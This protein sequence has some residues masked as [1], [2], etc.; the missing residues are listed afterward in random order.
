MIQAD[1][2]VGTLAIVLAI[3]LCVTAF[4][5]VKSNVHPAGVQAIRRRFGDAAAK[6]VVA[7]IALLLL[8]SGVMILRDLRPSF[9]APAMG[10][11]GARSDATAR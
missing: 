8:L 9:A 3:G 10:N 11:S 7:M 4:G 1:T 2:F 5:P 6:A